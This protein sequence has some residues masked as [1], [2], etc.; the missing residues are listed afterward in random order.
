MLWSS[1]STKKQILCVLNSDPI[2]TKQ[3]RIKATRQVAGLMVKTRERIDN[4]VRPGFII[5]LKS[6]LNFNSF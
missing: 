3:G 2:F 6:T 4:N 1:S 5:N